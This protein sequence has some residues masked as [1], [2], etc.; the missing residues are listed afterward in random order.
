MQ[1]TSAI[2]SVLLLLLPLGNAAAQDA[3][4]PQEAVKPTEASKAQEPPAHYYHLDFL[5]QELGVDG[6]PVNSRSYTTILSTDPRDPYMSIRT[7]S[8]VPVVTS[9]KQTDPAGERPETQYQYLNVGVTIGARG[10]R[11]I[12]TQ[13][14]IHLN[15]DESSLA[16]VSPAAP[17]AVDPVIRQNSWEAIVLIPIGKPTIV[18]SSDTLE[19]KGRTQLVV[20]AIPLQ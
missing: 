20:T 15:A 17:A 19:S 10:A 12:G 13:L 9:A 8:R 2:C 5:L 7:G 11:E 1:K 16:P 6:K 18:F 14:A 3:A 4:K